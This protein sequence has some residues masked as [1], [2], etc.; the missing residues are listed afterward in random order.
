MPKGGLISIRTEIVS[1]D[2]GFIE[3]H[4]YGKVGKYALVMV[5]D[6][7]EGMDSKTRERIFEPFFTTKDQGKGTGLGLSTVY[8]IVKQHD[9]YIET[10]SEPGKGTTFKIYLPLYRGVS[11]E[12]RKEADIVPIRGG[13]E[14]ILVAEDDAAL[15]KLT[16]TVLKN[17]GYSVI[18]AADGIDAVTKYG[19]N[20]GIVKLIILD[21]VMPKMNGKEA[22]Q[23][24]RMINPTI[25][26][27]FASG[28]AEDTFSKESL[29]T[30]GI[31]FILK[32]FSP[33]VLLRKVR[34]TLDA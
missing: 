8:G 9:G 27:I 16:S 20:R 21:G 33:S 24:I 32:P 15:R 28:Y 5:S 1:L 10:Y 4:G 3:S 31:H 13:S 12:V 11:E 30:S 19:E 23:E 18:E 34:E 22:F 2:E 14:T 6:T 7:G 25:K 17:Y 29:S 26:T